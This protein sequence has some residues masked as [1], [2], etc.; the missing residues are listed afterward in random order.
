MS[1][2]PD[3]GFY[4]RLAAV[5]SFDAFTEFDA[6]RPVPEDWVV[7]TA[8]VTGSTRAIAEGRYKEVNM[9]GAAV[10]TA[11][12]NAA[13]G[14][15]LPYVFGG[16]GGAVLVPG[17]LAEP[18]AQALGRLQR[19]S[20]ASYGLALRAAAI[21]VARLRAEGSDV[22]VL[23]LR[24]SPA[25][26]LAMLSGGGI[27]RADRILR[28]APDDRHVLAPPDDRAPDLGGL[29]CRWEPLEP[30]H[31]RMIAL[32]VRPRRAEEAA[33]V[34]ADTVA[35]IARILAE[36]IARHAPV[37]DGAL[38]FRFP[39]RGLWLEA[40]AAARGG[41][42]AL[43]WGRALATA[44]LQGLAERFRLRVGPYDQP[45]YREEL[46]TNTDFR[47]FDDALRIVLDVTPAQVAAIEAHLE[48]GYRAGRLVHGLHVAERALMTCLVFS[49]ERSEHVHFV[50]AAGGGF[51][52]AAGHLKRRLAGA[53]EGA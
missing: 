26:H 1:A 22:R 3:D 43:A 41:L 24:L 48:A 25:N 45:R 42:V 11:V 31:G 13:G 14:L 35:A 5:D 51:A 6:Y 32:I 17:R 40:R 27:E 18:A 30:R 8:D 36:P 16:D 21:P 2:P 44:A 53:A 37:S 20:E 15:E 19:L 50:D 23:K 46:K 7:L 10:I 34:L 28:E 9:V 47:K 49:L 29:S 4:A 12:L 39:P 52:M 33:A 38:R